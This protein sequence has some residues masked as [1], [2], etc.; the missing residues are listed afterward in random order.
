MNLYEN[1]DVLM[2]EIYSSFIYTMNTYYRDFIKKIH[3]EFSLEI[4]KL[5]NL[6]K[7]IV[8]DMYDKIIKTSVNNVVTLQSNIFQVLHYKLYLLN[9]PFSNSGIQG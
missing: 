1:K 2:P 9:I 7:K 6:E 4:V 3:D 5:D 8:I